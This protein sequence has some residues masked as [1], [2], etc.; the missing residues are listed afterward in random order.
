[1]IGL[2]SNE[3]AI[4]AEGQVALRLMTLACPLAGASLVVVAYFQS[5]GRVRQALLIT[6]GGTLLIKLPVLL[7][8]ANLFSLTGIWLSEVISELLLVGASLIL[9]RRFLKA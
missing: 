4:I 3:P 9:L 1:V 5:T 2:L 7:L 8:A 6:L